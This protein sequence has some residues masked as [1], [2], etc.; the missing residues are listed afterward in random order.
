MISYVDNIYL[1]CYYFSSI[2]L[3]LKDNEKNF[4]KFSSLNFLSILKY[5]F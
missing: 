4:I 3:S 2:N 1:L 5:C